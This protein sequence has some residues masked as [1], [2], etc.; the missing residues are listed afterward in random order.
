[1]PSKFIIQCSCCGYHQDFPN[2]KTWPISVTSAGWGSYGS[3]LYCPEC[4]RTWPERNPGRS[5]ASNGNTLIVA[6]LFV[7]NQKERSKIKQ[8][9]QCLIDNGIDPE[10]AQTVLQAL[11]Y[12]LLDEELYPEI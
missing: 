1:M 6:K 5:M 4:T 10:E 7:R 9:E 3:A 8:A 11:G 2:D 12:I